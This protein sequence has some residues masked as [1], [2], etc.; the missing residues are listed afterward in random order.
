MMTSIVEL[1]SS[2]PAPLYQHARIQL[3]IRAID[4][5]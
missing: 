5:P 2:E 3:K 1:N 4:I